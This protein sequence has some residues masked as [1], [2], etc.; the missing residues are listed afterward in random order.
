MT[1]IPTTLKG[2]LS[3]NRFQLLIANDHIITVIVSKLLSQ[4]VEKKLRSF[5][6]D[7]H[8]SNFIYL[9][10]SRLTGVSVLDF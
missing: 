2:T 3:A 8:F 9:M 6:R 4:D 5:K 10:A 7:K 1:N